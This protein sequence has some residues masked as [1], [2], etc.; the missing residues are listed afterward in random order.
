MFKKIVVTVLAVSLS[1]TLAY[2]QASTTTTTTETKAPV[3]HKKAAVKA[4]MTT[5]SETT[6]TTPAEPRQVLS[7]DMLKKISST[8][9]APGF[10]A[11]VG[12][13]RKNVCQNKATAPDIAY[14][15]VWAQKGT[16][17]YKPSAKGPCTLDFAEQVEK[18]VITKSDYKSGPPLKYGV[19]AQ[20][21]FRAAKGMATT[22]TDTN[23]KTK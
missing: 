16:E 15:C 14:S 19:E 1:A 8:I 22:T 6:V 9:C 17:A 23:T 10:K 7:E 21:C 11:H 20:C 5:T 12:S 2:G 18:V 4:K 13:D 3:V